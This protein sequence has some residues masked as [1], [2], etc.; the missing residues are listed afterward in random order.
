[1]TSWIRVDRKK[2][3]TKERP[4]YFQTDEAEIG[5]QF[6]SYAYAVMVAQANQRELNVYDMSNPVSVNFKMLESTFVDLSGVS[7]VDTALPLSTSLGARNQ[8]RTVPYLSSLKVDALR[9][10]V[11]P[12][13]EWKGG[14]LKE[15]EAIL[16]AVR[17]PTS[18][19]ICVHLRNQPGNSIL[20]SRTVGV[21]AYAQAAKEQVAAMKLKQPPNVFVISEAPLL[22][23]EFRKRIDPSWKIFTLPTPAETLRPTPRTRQLQFNNYM[24]ELYVAQRCPVIVSTLNSPTGR[25][26]FLTSDK[27][28]FIG[29]DTTTM[30]Y[31]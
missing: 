2:A 11:Q 26:L 19:D 23:D 31:Y 10:S 16:K 20:G 27:V 4:Y 13:L 18:F 1:M 24:A 7:Y 12:I 28:E 21:T 9:A 17:L 30:T 8:G 14:A 25:F 15:I 29:L 22:L 6:T 3:D 5:Q